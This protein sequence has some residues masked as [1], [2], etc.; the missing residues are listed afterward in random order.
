MHYFY[1]VCHQRR[2][3]YMICLVVEN[4]LKYCLPKLFCSVNMAHYK[5]VIQYP[6]ENF[7]ILCLAPTQIVFR[8]KIPI[9]L[10]R[11]LNSLNF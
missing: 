10:L 2:H 9:K 11:H 8:D 4:V 5:E 1:F 7:N 6:T 3:A